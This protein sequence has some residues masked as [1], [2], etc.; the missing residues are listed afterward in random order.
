[1]SA[2]ERELVLGIDGR[3]RPRELEEKISDLCLSA[4][5]TPAGEQVLQYLKNITLMAPAPSGVRSED[6]HALEGARRL[7]A[8]LLQRIEHGKRLRAGDQPG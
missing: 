1:M 8:M 6:L 5:T 4:F 2:P 3:K 7:V